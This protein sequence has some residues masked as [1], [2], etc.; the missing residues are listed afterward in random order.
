VAGLKLGPL[1][2][3]EKAAPE[4][5]A[6]RQVDLRSAEFAQGVAS[7]ARLKQ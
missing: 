6:Q 3:E 2:P 4:L 1:A 7:L 5:P